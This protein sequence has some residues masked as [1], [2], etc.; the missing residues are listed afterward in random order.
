MMITIIA[1]VLACKTLVMRLR[2]LALFF[3]ASLVKATTDVPGVEAVALFNL[4][5]LSRPFLYLLHA[6]LVLVKVDGLVME[7]PRF[8]LMKE[9]HDVYSF[10]CLPPPASGY[11]TFRLLPLSVTTVVL[12]PTYCN[13]GGV[14][15]IRLWICR[16]PF[17]A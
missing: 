3:A 14:F 8:G 4:E 17:S 6:V 15:I 13:G 2:R 7:V 5:L 9:S 16:S 1:P 12:L 11:N 10:L